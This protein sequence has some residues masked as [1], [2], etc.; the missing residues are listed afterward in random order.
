[1]LIFFFF[2]ER[3]TERSWRA[4]K[5]RRVARNEVNFF[6]YEGRKEGKKR[7]T[8]A[9]APLISRRRD[10]RVESLSSYSSGPTHA[11]IARSTKAGGG[12]RFFSFFFLLFFDRRPQSRRDYPLNLSILLSGGKETN[13]DFL[14]SGERTGKSPAL[15]P[16][17]LP[18]GNV[19]FGRIHLSRGCVPRP[20]PS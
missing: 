8:R 10:V 19:V 5:R 4:L 18:L 16:A 15:N 7:R 11:P 3:I 6:L 13:Q 12:V 1:M 2:N 9:R 20:S 14:S 17:V